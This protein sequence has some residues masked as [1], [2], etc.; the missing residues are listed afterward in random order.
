MK[1]LR[2]SNLFWLITLTITTPCS[3]RSLLEVLQTTPDLSSIYSH[4][5]ASSNLTKYL[6]DAN[7]FTFL[8]PSNSAIDRFVSSNSKN[9]SND[10]LE[11]TVQ[12][13]LLR[14]GFPSLSFSNTSQFAASN[15]VNTT[16]ANVTGG[17]AVELVL[18]TNGT[19]Q[20][21]SGNKTIGAATSTVIKT[22]RLRY[23]HSPTL[24]TRSRIS[25]ALVD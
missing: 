4:I 7:N 13:S 1:L 15:L 20:V 3:A 23:F 10:L 25:F 21:V 17:Q 6:A 12:Y 16:Y 9:L 19:A 2:R 8:A 5:N 24:L 22:Q 14:G 18:A 11:A